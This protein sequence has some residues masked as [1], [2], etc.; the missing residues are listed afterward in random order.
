MPV[1]K[2][3]MMRLNDNLKRA[4]HSGDGYDDYMTVY[5]FLKHKS[6]LLANR[7]KKL[8]YTI[9]NFFE[10]GGEIVSDTDDVFDVSIQGVRLT[11]KY[12]EAGDV[13]DYSVS[14]MKRKKDV[15]N[16]LLSLFFCTHM[17][18]IYED[19]LLATEEQLADM[20]NDNVLRGMSE[21][22]DIIRGDRYLTVGSIS[23][24]KIASEDDPDPFGIF[25]EER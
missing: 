22:R 12:D 6:A 15:V 25:A 13:T 8:R 23:D 4:V 10:E 7:I 20:D 16:R 19:I 24:V 17:I 3:P 1:K 18:P 2:S 5:Q 11:I 21:L 14:G 9:A